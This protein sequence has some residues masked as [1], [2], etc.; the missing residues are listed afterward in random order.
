MASFVR[1]M[2]D[3]ESVWMVVS[4]K[5]PFK[6]SELLWDDQT[7]L[8]LVTESISD[9]DGIHVCDVEFALPI[10]SYTWDTLQL[11]KSKYPMKDFVLLLGSDTAKELLSWKNGSRIIDTHQ[12]WVYPRQG[13]DCNLNHANIIKIPAP[14]IELSSTLIRQWVEEGKNIKWMVPPA[15]EVYIKK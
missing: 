1:N 8:K 15:V 9:Y 11:L 7:R 4:P 6:A 10:P 14:L 5:N 12:I 13:I 3:V 2:Q